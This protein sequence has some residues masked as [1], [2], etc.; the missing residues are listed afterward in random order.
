MIPELEQT[1]KKTIRGEV[2]FDALSRYLYSTD[3]SIYQIEPTG[4]VIPRTQ[5]DLT[6]II[7]TCRDFG[8][9]IT[10]RGGGTSLGG[11]AVGEGLHID[12]SKYLNR[13][14]EINAEERWVRVEPGV[15]LDQLNQALLPHKLW[16]GPDVA[17]SNRATLG[18]MVGNNSA[19]VRSIIYGKTVDHVLELDVVL[20]SGENTTLKTLNRQQLKARIAHAGHE[21]RL[22]RQMLPEIQSHRKEILDRYPKILR[23]VSG[24]NLDEVLDSDNLNLARLVV[25]SEGT[26]ALTAS[27]KLNLVPR[28]AVRGLGLVYFDNLF[29]ALDALNPL[30]ETHP[31]AVELMDDMLLELAAQSLAYSRKLAFMEKPAK[32]MLMVEFM[33]DSTAEVEAHLS[34]L[35]KFVKANQ[36][37]FHYSQTLDTRVQTDIWAIRKAGLP[38]LYSIP[39]ERKPIAFVEDT[40]VAPEKLPAFVRRFSEI[41]ADHDTTAA[42]YAHASV[43]CLHIRPLL[44]LKQPEDVVRMKSLSQA[45]FNLVM[46]YGGSMS[47]EHGDGLARSAYNPELFGPTIYALFQKVKQ[48]WDPQ[49]LLNPGKIVNAPPMD[50]NL[51]F[52]KGYKPQTVSSLL[53]VKSS[54]S[55]TNLIEVCHGCGGC[56]KESTGTMCPTYMATR[57]EADST[58]GRA[59]A[60]R[61]YLVS[62]E[63]PS[64]DLLDVMKLCIGCKACKAEC[65]SKVDMARLKSEVLH[66]HH[67]TTGARWRDKLLAHPQ[68]VN[69]AGSLFAPLSNWVNQMSPLRGLLNRAVGLA[70]QRKLPPFANI[71]FD[72]WFAKHNSPPQKQQVILFND[73]FM[74]HNYPSIGQSA[75]AIFEA[76]G[77][78]VIV[79]PQVCCGR[80]Q[81][82]LGFLD[83]AKQSAQHLEQTLKPW[84]DHNIPI[85]GCEP[86]CMLTFR[87]EYPALLGHDTPLAHLTRVFPEWLNEVLAQGVPNPFGE[88]SQKLLFHEHCHQKSLVGPEVSMQ[89][90]RQ[91]PGYQVEL[92]N[93]GCCGM[94]GAFGYE[95]EHMQLSKQIAGDRLLPAIAKADNETQIVVHGVSCHQQ[96]SGLSQRQPRH[97][98]EVLADALL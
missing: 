16:F 47:G 52:G 69:R 8:I 44:D 21:G 81:I 72:Y 17:T 22:Y 63:P 15:V 46:E 98:V 29:S 33:G 42:Y 90:L 55:F 91:V 30:L 35:K 10:A 3:A 62:G 89:A 49:S 78:E 61:Q 50:Q 75:V 64:K 2:R 60:L 38:L 18:G 13:I 27:M 66:L 31:S 67:Q 88:L 34:R 24:Y 1:L 79:P 94:A 28:P 73:C 92:I 74:N 82:S 20:S 11:Q 41:V 48:Y 23:R 39:G 58:R 26:L 80:P 87:D 36:I 14:L 56:R 93:A 37:G 43:G 77:Y 65:P 85:V 25:G 7:N 76:M 54:E 19:G 59:N 71:P 32:S 86:S 45:I 84:L 95:A 53:Q 51:R 6:V 68:W 9:P 12:C 5:D 40:A 96:I 4:V 70:P 97:L 57:E 83:E